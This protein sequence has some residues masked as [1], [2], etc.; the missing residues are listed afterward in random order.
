MV[1]FANIMREKRLNFVV[2]EKGRVM[3]PF[4]LHERDAL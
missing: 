4:G 2:E 1:R 3:G